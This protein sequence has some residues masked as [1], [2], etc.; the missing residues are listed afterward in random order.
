MILGVSF[1][2]TMIFVLLIIRKVTTK[3]RSRR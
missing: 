2:F 3:P 1:M